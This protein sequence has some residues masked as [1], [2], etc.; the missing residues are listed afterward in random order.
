MS[1]DLDLE[2]KAIQIVSAL[3]RE[4]RIADEKLQRIKRRR[5]AVEKLVETFRNTRRE[6]TVLEEGPTTDVPAVQ[7]VRARNVGDLALQFLRDRIP[8]ATVRELHTAL[9]STGA[10]V[11][12]E[13]YM[14]TIVKKLTAKRLVRVERDGRARRYYAI[15][16]RPIPT[17]E[18]ESQSRMTQ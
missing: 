7:M 3:K 10:A 9:T 1:A 5:I 11:G 14:F 15:H 4:E 13:E 8:G 12:S 16:A 18:A 2:A 17:I 6:S